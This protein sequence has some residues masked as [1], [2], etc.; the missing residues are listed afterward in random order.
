MAEVNQADLD[1]MAAR[2]AR[3]EQELAG[4]PN[5]QIPPEEQAL[6]ERLQRLRDG[7]AN[8]TNTNMPTKSQSNS[9][10]QGGRL[11]NRR[12]KSKKSKS[13]KFKKLRKSKSRNH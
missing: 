10:Q 7:I 9:L 11:Y 12:K 6:R 2:L 8:R 5:V 3:M 4:M 1:N 13:K